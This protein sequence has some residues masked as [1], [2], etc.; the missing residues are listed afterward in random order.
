MFV[1][2]MPSEEWF[3]KTTSLLENTSA[4]LVVIQREAPIFSQEPV[5][6]QDNVSTVREIQRGSILF[7]PNELS[8]RQAILDFDAWHPGSAMPSASPYIVLVGG[9]TN[10][11]PEVVA[12]APAADAGTAMTT[13]VP[14]PPA[15]PETTGTTETA[16]AAKTP[17]TPARPATAET[18]APPAPVPD[19]PA[20]KAKD[21]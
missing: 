4:N 7:Q 18:P 2:T 16:T 9:P 6:P 20:D 3:E 12:P 1:R 17:V 19:V 13:A 8:W 5:K 10:S 11:V 15:T 14:E 21:L